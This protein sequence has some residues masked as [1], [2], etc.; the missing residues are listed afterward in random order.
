MLVIKILDLK[1]TSAVTQS[2]LSFY[3]KDGVAQAVASLQ[4]VQDEQRTVFGALCDVKAKALSVSLALIWNLKPS[5]Y[6]VHFQ[7]WHNST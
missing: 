7:K 6:H 1:G 5:L 4:S 2:N 3:W